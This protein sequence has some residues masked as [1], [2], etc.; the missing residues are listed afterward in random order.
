[1]IISSSNNSFNENSIKYYSKS[2][3]QDIYSI[4]CLEDNNRILINFNDMEKF[5]E[6]Y[7]VT[8]EEFLELLSESNK[9]EDSNNITFVVNEEDVLLDPS[10]VKNFSNIVINPISE[11]S[12]CVYL[13]DTIINE[14]IENDNDLFDLLCEE[15]S[16]EELARRIKENQKRSEN[17]QDNANYWSKYYGRKAE[18]YRAIRD[19]KRQE[20][21]YNTEN[22]KNSYTDNKTTKNTEKDNNKEQITDVFKSK[23]NSIKNNFHNNKKMYVKNAKIAAGVGVAVLLAKRISALRKRQRMLEMQQRYAANQQ[24]KGAIGRIIERIKLAIRRLLEKLKGKSNRDYRY[25]RYR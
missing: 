6:D 14:Y 15:S 21:D 22:P 10:I 9:I 16:D 17:I 1:M 7:D 2:M 24:R 20:S 12:Y 19:K 18:A 25:N 13:C 11:N 5:C 4:I 3:D 23:F 8:T